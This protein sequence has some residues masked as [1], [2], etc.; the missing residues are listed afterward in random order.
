MLFDER[1]IY[2][3]SKT[4]ASGFTGD[5]RRLWLV[6]L[7]GAAA[8]PAFSDEGYLFSGGADWIL[9]AYQPE[10]RIR[11]R[12]RSLYGP[13]PEGDY[14]TANPRPSSWA[15]YSFRFETTEVTDR[16]EHIGRMIQAG[17][18]G[19][20]EKDLTAY[21][22]EL[23]DSLGY[24][25]SPDSL[26]RPPVQVAQRAE[27]LRLLGYLGSRET[28]PFLAKLYAQDRDTLVKAA[29]SEAIGRIGVDPDGFAL[30]AFTA[31]VV[32][33]AAYRDE[34]VMLATAIATGALCRFSGPP[35]SETGIHILT[36]LTWADNPR[37]VRLKA[38]EELES[39]RQFEE[40]ALP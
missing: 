29:A 28:V 11:Q 30:R 17:T 4:G 13:A 9:Y 10:N 26:V 32:P 5:G 25:S 19:E 31:L 33:L 35:L 27:A 21:L 22:M 40:R 39:L 18:V 1:G 15:A 7:E 3:L 38:R 2:V 37:A 14:G 16:L 36:S 23:A 24:P 20:D 6:R 8:I 12:K 34:Q